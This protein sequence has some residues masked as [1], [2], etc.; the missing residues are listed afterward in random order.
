VKWKVAIFV[1]DQSPARDIGDCLLAVS[2]MWPDGLWW[3]LGEVGCLL[4]RRVEL[5]D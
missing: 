4:W 2:N 5:G 3:R 1:K